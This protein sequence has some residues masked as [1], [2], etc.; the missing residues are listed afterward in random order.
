MA[1]DELVC[2]T[3]AHTAEAVSVAA[4]TGEG[5]DFES[6]QTFSYAD[7]STPTVSS[8]TPNSG[9]SGESITVIG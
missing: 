2:E 1:G 3:S 7:S 4:L 9:S 8:V 6:T 5:A